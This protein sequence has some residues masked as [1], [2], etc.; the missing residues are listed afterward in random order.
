MKESVAHK[1]LRRNAVYILAPEAYF[2]GSDLSVF[3]GQQPRDAFEG[4]GFTS[5]I[6]AEERY[7]GPLRNPQ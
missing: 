6:G 7:N 2:A 5:T 1:P 4:G 3:Q